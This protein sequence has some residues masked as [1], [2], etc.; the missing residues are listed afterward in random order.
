M[1][2]NKKPYEH[3][4]YG[5]CAPGNIENFGNNTF[6]VG[7]FQWWPKANGKGLKRSPVKYRVKGY[8]ADAEKV[9]NRAREICK[10]LDNPWRPSTFYGKSETVK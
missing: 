3:D 8:V 9:Y 2:E 6:S 4:F 5:A 1:L 10:E 7:I